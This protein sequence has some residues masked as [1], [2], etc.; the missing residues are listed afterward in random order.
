VETTN[1]RIE[2]HVRTEQWYVCARA[3][4]TFNVANYITHLV[5]QKMSVTQA[6]KQRFKN[7]CCTT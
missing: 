3:R 1:S 2:R 7:T 5:H 4:G 6:I